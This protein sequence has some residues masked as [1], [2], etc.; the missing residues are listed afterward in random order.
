MKRYFVA[1]VFSSLL[2]SISSAEV[3][4]PPG[5]ADARVRVVDY[6]P[7][8]VYTIKT[9]YG[10]AT[11]I[12][13]S[14]DEMITD[15]AL[16][17]E[18]AWQS[19]NRGSNFFIKPAAEYGDT[20]LIIVTT[21]R[22]YHFSLKVAPLDKNNKDAWKD[23]S[24]IYSL[25]FRYPDEERAKREAQAALERDK[26]KRIE[27]Q[28]ELDSTRSRKGHNLNYWVAGD[29]EVS[30]T[31]AYDDGTFMY[32]TFNAN[33][34]F[35]AVYEEDSNGKESLVN[36]NTISTNTIEVRRMVRSLI[37]RRG[38]KVARIINK[39]FDIDAGSDPVSGTVSPRIERIIKEAD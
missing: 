20:N 18:K 7:K 36:V 24:L 5:S 30:P 17:D 22:I 1:A 28:K 23:S 15:F 14:Q 19:S 27:V 29:E 16:G 4:A 8:Q 31:G 12:Q 13:L 37:L 39:S 25:A 6:N 38:D 34:D 3:L 10:V 11:H 21:K 35:P 33:R 2:I 32:L 9:F 26:K